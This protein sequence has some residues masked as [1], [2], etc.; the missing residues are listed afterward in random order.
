MKKSIIYSIIFILIN[1]LAI[2]AQ[3]AVIANK[4]VSDKDVNISK[5][6]DIYTLNV[7]FW[8]DGNKI[9]VFDLKKDN[10]IQI[11]FYSSL[12]IS[13]ANIMVIWTKKQFS[14]KA[15]PPELLDYEEEMLKK[16]ATTPNAIGYIQSSKVTND[17]KV[18]FE[19][20]FK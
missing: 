7:Q 9:K 3:I 6:L 12:G 14:G 15:M 10:V 19:I 17:V 13:V 4:S 5:L 18:L 11:K 1:C 16:V 2:K 20:N 8:D